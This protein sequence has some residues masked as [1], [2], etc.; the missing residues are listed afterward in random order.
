VADGV[1]TTLIFG[2]RFPFIYLTETHGLHAYA[3]FDGCSNETYV[4]PVRIAFLIDKIESENIPVVF[5]IELSDRRIANV[6]AEATGAEL[7][8][9]HSAHNVTQAEFDA[10]I[11]YLD[12]MQRNVEQI[13]R[14]LN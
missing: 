11:T 3:A 2:D 1:R 7:L 9:L 10:G 8:E 5:Y 14:A 4:S 6:I 12:I 13:R